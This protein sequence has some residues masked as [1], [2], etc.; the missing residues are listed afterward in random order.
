MTLSLSL[1]H[2]YSLTFPLPPSLKSKAGVHKNKGP[3]ITS[4][5]FGITAGYGLIPLLR[6][7]KYEVT[8]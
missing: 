7:H 4:T 5:S 6:M 2:S 1:S 3:Y 8:S